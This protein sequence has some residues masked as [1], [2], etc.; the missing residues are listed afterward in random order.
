MCCVNRRTIMSTKKQITTRQKN[1]DI[2]RLRGVMAQ[3]KN[4]EY[5]SVAYLPEDTTFG[6]AVLSYRED[7]CADITRILI[8]AKRMIERRQK[9]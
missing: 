4:I 7:D 9:C 8:A 6:A 3:V 2:F 5:E 1:W